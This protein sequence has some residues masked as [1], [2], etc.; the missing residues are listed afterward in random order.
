M[1]WL[2]RPGTVSVWLSPQTLQRNGAGHRWRTSRSDWARAEVAQVVSLERTFDG[3]RGARNPQFLSMLETRYLGRRLG[4][5]LVRD[6]LLEVE[7]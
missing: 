7:L 3:G 5:K 4:A 2:F 1:W 6:M